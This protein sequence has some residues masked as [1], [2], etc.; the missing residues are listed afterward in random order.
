M[1]QPRSDAPD[2]AALLNSAPFAGADAESVGTSAGMRGHAPT[3]RQRLEFLR[4]LIQRGIVNEGF[5]NDQ[6][7]PSH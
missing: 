2:L 5:E 3:T 4:Y 7:D 1:A 6:S